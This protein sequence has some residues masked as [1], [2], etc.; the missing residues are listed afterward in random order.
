MYLSVD[1]TQIACSVIIRLKP[2]LELFAAVSNERSKNAAYID[3][4]CAVKV[5]AILFEKKKTL[6]KISV[7]LHEIQSFGTVQRLSNS[8][9]QSLIETRSLPMT[10]DSIYAT[11][12]AIRHNNVVWI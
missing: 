6:C 3:C 2:Q 1:L 9:K 12:K 11:A 10:V 4:V 5:T 7:R 8:P